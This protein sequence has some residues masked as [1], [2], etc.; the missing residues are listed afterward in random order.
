MNPSSTTMFSLLDQGGPFANSSHAPPT[1]LFSGQARE[2]AKM[3]QTGYEQTKYRVIRNQVFDL[4]D[5]DCYSQITPLLEDPSRRR[6]V[7]EKAYR[8]LGNTFGINNDFNDIVASVHGYAQ[9]A[10]TVIRYLKGKVLANFTP[11]I[12]M[13]NEIEVITN[14]VDL[15]LIIFNDHYHQKARF[16]AKR[17]LMLMN[18]AGAIDQRERETN[19]EAHFASFL[20]FLNRYVWSPGSKIG[21]LKPAY[22]LSHHRKDDFS[23]EKW[24]FVDPRTIDS[25]HPGQNK[26]L[27]LLKRRRFTIEGRTIPIYVAI[28]KKP[29]EAKVL[30]LLRKEEENPAVA[31][32][33]E[34][35]LMAVLDNMADVKAFQNHLTRSARAADSFMVL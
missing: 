2:M 24:Q 33:D 23:C 10:D 27:T 19:I 4:L 13:T 15:L 31:V 5:V 32:D 16:E 9:T 29:P 34:L 3:L 11:Y 14:P 8:L 18:Q 20:D 22:V 30:K 6:Q 7:T 1:T 35:G 25:F 28:R 21:E 26:K 17:K 12:E